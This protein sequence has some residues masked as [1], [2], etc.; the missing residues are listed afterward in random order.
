MKEGNAMHDNDIGILLKKINDLMEKSANRDMK[1]SGLTFSQHHVLVFLK[2]RKGEPASLKE[3]EREF[4]V[5]QSTM[6]GLVCRLEEKGLIE[7]YYDPSDKRVKMIRL[8]SE[9]SRIV[10]KTHRNFK[11]AQKLLVKGLSAEENAKLLEMLKTVYENVL[12][13]QDE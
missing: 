6:A 7:S 5:A 2:K 8:S 11:A 1:E 12:E 13:A 4:K 3:A 9:G 10:E